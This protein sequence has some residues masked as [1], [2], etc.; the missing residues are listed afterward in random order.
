MYAESSSNT[1]EMRATSLHR[2]GVLVCL[3]ALLAAIFAHMGQPAT[4][5][6]TSEQTTVAAV[7]EAD[8]SC[9]EEHV[10]SPQHCMQH[11]QCSLHAVVPA[12]PAIWGSGFKAIRPAAEPFC[13]EQIV[14][15]LR[16]PPKAIKIL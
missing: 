5:A 4:A 16:R 9:P 2:L 7:H 15:P 3:V 13:G 6:A 14:S 8:G 11:S 1:H 10:L 12:A